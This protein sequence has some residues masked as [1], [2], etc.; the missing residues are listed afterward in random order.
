MKLLLSILF[1]AGLILNTVS[2]IA[3]KSSSHAPQ[4][5]AYDIPNTE[6]IKSKGVVLNAQEAEEFLKQTLATT[7]DYGFELVNEV[8]STYENHYTFI[9]RYKGMAVYQSMVKVNTTKKG[10]ITSIMSSFQEI[11]YVQNEDLLSLQNLK[12][13]IPE[14]ATLHSSNL[15]WAMSDGMYKPCL[16][17]QY[18]NENG[19]DFEVLF[20]SEN[21]KVLEIERSSHFSAIDTTA[22]AMVFLPDP[23]TSAHTVYGG[24]FSDNQDATNDSLDKYRVSVDLN[25]IY[26]NGDF[27]LENDYVKITEHSLPVI[28]PVTSTTPFFNFDRSQTGFE[29]VNAFYHITQ[30]QYYL[31]SLGFMNLVNYQI[32]V[33]CHGFNGSDNSAFTAS[34]NPPTLTFGEG[35]VDDAEDT[36]VIIHEY[37]HAILESA[38]PNSNFGTERNAMDEGFADYMAASYSK[39]IDNYQDNYVFN[40]D[41]HNTFW[42]GRLVTSNATYPDQLVYNLYGDAPMWSSAILRIE[43]N[44]S[45]EV[46]HTI[47]LQAAFS[48]TSNMTMA[49]GAQLFIDKDS[50]I[51]NGAHYAE[52]C[53]TF[54]DKGMI[55]N[56]YTSRPNTMVGVSF[57]NN[58]KHAFLVKNSEGFARGENAIEIEGKNNFSLTIYNLMGR[59]IITEKSINGTVFISPEYLQSGVYLFLIQDKN[60]TETVKV[61]RY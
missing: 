8:S 25:L 45:R 14:K 42:P 60:Q 17:I 3:Q 31:Q 15:V 47:A 58:S 32:A 9:E 41:G 61:I 6:L 57:I 52:V 50:L 35:G 21:D 5:Y 51:Y 29:D 43:R 1:F 55:Q 44:T 13:L 7:D 27:V 22:K 36:D 10:I 23:I 56:C 18:F 30:Q 19:L 4:A 38:A 49:Q 33:D 12:P 34:T 39:A 2:A 11:N 26:D 24:L 59:E 16:L 53:Y 40:W 48:Y 37:T 54:K 46:A 20:D 28:A